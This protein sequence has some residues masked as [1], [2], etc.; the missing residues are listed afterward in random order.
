MI[1]KTH[2]NQFEK[3]ILKTVLSKITSSWWFPLIILLSAQLVLWG[4][5]LLYTSYTFDTAGNL[6]KNI[7]WLIEILYLLIQAILEL[8]YVV[9]SCIKKNRKNLQPK[10]LLPKITNKDLLAFY[11]TKYTIPWTIYYTLIG[12]FLFLSSQKYLV[13]L[14]LF[15]WMFLQLLQGKCFAKD[16]LLERKK[17]LRK[18]VMRLHQQEKAS[19]TKS[20]HYAIIMADDSGLIP[21]TFGNGSSL[22]SNVLLF[23]QETEIDPF[24]ADNPEQNFAENWESLYLASDFFIYA[25]DST[26]YTAEELAQRCETAVTSYRFPV[27]KPLYLLI[28]GHSSMLRTLMQ[29]YA[30]LPE[31]SIQCLNSWEQFQIQ[32]L[33]SHYMDSRMIPSYKDINTEEDYAQSLGYPAEELYWSS[34]L[35]YFPHMKTSFLASAMLYTNDTQYDYWNHMSSCCYLLMTPLEKIT[36]SD[37]NY[38]YHYLNSQTKQILACFSKE[39][40]TFFFHAYNYF[41]CGFFSN[42][43][44]W[45]EP[46]IA[47][48][49]EFEYANLALRFVHYYLYCKHTSG[50]IEKY[51]KEDKELGEG[52]WALTQPEDMLYTSLHQKVDVSEPML[53][54]ALF[55]LKNIFGVEHHEDSLDFLHLTNIL[56]ITRNITRGHG[57]IRHDMQNE[58]W[59]ALYV[60]LILLNEMLSVGYLEI[61]LEKEY[62]NVG[63]AED[64]SWYQD[65]QYAIIQDDT[66]LLLHG[67]SRKNHFEYINYYKGNVVVP[68]ITERILD[69]V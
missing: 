19:A 4:Y 37:L 9:S 14:L 52:I 29:K 7:L 17:A 43:F 54:N 67:I 11:N 68:E 49:A 18:N 20:L 5:T 10:I 55:I 51:F 2:M 24:L 58:L 27:S 30:W 3:D 13:I 35:E 33:I 56:R 21:S 59:F 50:P 60:L 36:C 38:F 62:V 15:L 57:A 64:T 39:Y 16:E 65:E 22:T 53:H 42:I 23:D 45:Q 46:S 61:A 26:K 34:L 31:V 8:I 63:Y 6:E 44:R 12:I 40:S 1:G 41:I 32:D 28:K 25:F 47:V 66:P 69:N 48:M